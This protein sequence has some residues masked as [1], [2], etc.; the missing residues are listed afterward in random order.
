MLNLS[1]PKV[2]EGVSTPLNPKDSWEDKEDYDATA[3]KLA[4]LFIEN[5]KNYKDNEKGQALVVAGPQLSADIV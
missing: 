1:I 4:E 2:I 3:R 5:F